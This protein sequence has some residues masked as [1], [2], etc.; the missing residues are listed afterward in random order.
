LALAALIAAVVIPLASGASDKTFTLSVSPSTVCSSATNGG[1]STVLTLR[2]T[3]KS[4]SLGAAEVYF[5][6][7]TVFSVTSPA[8][9]RANTTSTTSGGTKD[10]VAFGNLNLSTGSPVQ[11]TVTFNANAQFSGPVTAV[12]KQSNQFNDTQ[13]GANLFDLDPAQGTFPTIRLVPCVS[14]AGRVYQDR[15]VDFVYTTGTGA[16]DDSDVPKAWTVR[17]YTNPSTVF[18]TLTSSSSDGAY[19]FTGVPTGSDYKI[20]VAAAGPTDSGSLWGLQSPAG[21]AQCGALSTASGAPSTSSG[22]LLPGLSAAATGQ[23]FVVVPITDLFGAGDTST[24]GGYTVVGGTNPGSKP[25]QNYVQDAWVDSSGRTNFRF[26]PITPCGP[27][28]DCSKKIYLLETL[29]ADLALGDL[30]GQQA[31]I[32]Y[33]DLAPFLDSELKQMPYCNV[34]PRQAGGAVATSGVLP[35]TNT[36]C[37]VSGSQA[38]VAG[39][40]V[41]VQYLVYTAYDGGRQI[42]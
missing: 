16:F 23:D 5:P 38:V 7:N 1:A 12:V 9:L 13:G 33:D 40:K 8:S 10:I 19:T 31:S 28:Q 11:V 26:S 20:C 27:P 4:A 3:A 36:S 21:N 15:N 25:D 6:P 39:G 29:T 37:I 34:D 32:L 18:K 14:V 24:R 41:H 42:G 17:L 2:N 22:R 35:G 30:A